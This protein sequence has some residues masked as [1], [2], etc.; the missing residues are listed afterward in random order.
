MKILPLCLVPCTHLFL[1]VINEA[2]EN[3]QNSKLLLY[4]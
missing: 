1:P 2:L 4:L 3:T